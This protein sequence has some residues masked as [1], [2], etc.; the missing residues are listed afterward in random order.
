MSASGVHI[1]YVIT[2]LEV[3]G[4]PLHLRRLVG[5]V[6]DRGYRT[7]VVSLAPLGPVGD[8]LRLD[9]VTTHSC[10]GRGGRDFRVIARLA[11]LMRL[12]RPDIVHALLFHANFA[13]RRAAKKAGIPRDRVL[14]E[15]QTVE[16]ERRWHLWVDRF[17]HRGAR[18]TIGNSPSVIDHLSAR[19]RI[20]RDRLRLVRGGIDAKRLA[21]APSLGRAVLPAPMGAKLLLWTGRL[22]PIKGLSTLLEACARLDPAVDAHLL[23]AGDGPLRGELERQANDLGIERR[24]HFLGV[25]RDVPSLLTAVDL[26]VFPSLTEGLPNALLEAMAAGV[27]VVTTDAPGCR[28]LVEDGRTGLVVPCRDASGLADAIGALL[29][30]PKRAARLSVAAKQEVSEHWHIEGTYAAYAELYREVA[31]GRRHGAESPRRP[32]S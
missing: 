10:E 13:A 7:T 20:P 31:G 11:E 12:E 17:T 29:R 15:I 32:S 6:R 14:C 1:L 4:V 8:Q 18:L 16:I 3:G 19:A 27:P 21:D 23:L 28:D 25:R 5:A 9:G 26:F 30:D 2:D 22:D 24:T